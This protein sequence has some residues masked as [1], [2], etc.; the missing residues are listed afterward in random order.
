[1][2]AQDWAVVALTVAAFV[3]AL[4]PYYRSQR[5]WTKRM[6]GE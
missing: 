5:A 4:V 6:R 3:L 1:M 2:T